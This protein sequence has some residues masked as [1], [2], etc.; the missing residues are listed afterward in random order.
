MDIIVI[1]AGYGGI[2]A[3]L[4][5]ARLFRRQ[6]ECRVHLIDKNPYHT[7]KTQLHEAA[8]RHTSVVIPIADIIKNRPIHFHAATVTG[9]DLNRRL[10]MLA[11]SALPFDYLVFA[12]GSLANYYNI[13]GVA[14]HS[15]PLQ[16]AEDAER[17]FRHLRGLCAS[18][19]SEPNRRARRDRLR[20]VIGGGGLSGVEFAA[21]LADHATLCVKE[22]APA[23][24]TDVEVVIIEGSERI[25]PTMEETVV[26]RIEHRLLTKGIKIMTRTMITALTPDSVTLSTGE[27]IKSETLVWTGGIR[28]STLAGESGLAVGPMGRI[29]V[30]EF[31]RARGNPAIYAI[32]DNALAVNPET[33]RPVPAAAQFALQ[34]GRL[35]AENIHAAV[36]GGEPTPYRPKVLGE[37]VSLGRH[38]AVG[39]MALPLS[40]KITFV[41]FLASLLKAAT[42][43]KHLILLRKE[44]RNWIRY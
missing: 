20:F 17:I 18:A 28:V 4:R 39:W 8:I 26:K 7:L 44:S 41:G 1:G 36:T 14:E 3:A 30:D 21:E 13:P 2:T 19:G 34:Q 10:V 38:L 42:A 22:H 31:L 25:L 6:T 15:F 5:L 12:L 35:V 11:E 16:T 27:R 33:G 43:E 40:K 29:V 24:P 37:V 32:G 9:I 23:E